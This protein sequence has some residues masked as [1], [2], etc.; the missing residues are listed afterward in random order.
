MRL[1]GV[2]SRAKREAQAF[3][4]CKPLLKRSNEAEIQGRMACHGKTGHRREI[5]IGDRLFFSLG[6]SFFFGLVYELG[7]IRW[8]C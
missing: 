6:G 7:K 3:R 4:L 8:I 1:G 2:C 5:P